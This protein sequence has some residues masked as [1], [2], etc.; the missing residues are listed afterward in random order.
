MQLWEC[1]EFPIVVCLLQVYH[2]CDFSLMV[3]IL[4]KARLVVSVDFLGK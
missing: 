2:H 4:I 3:S 1:L